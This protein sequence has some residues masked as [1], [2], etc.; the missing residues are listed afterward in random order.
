MRAFGVLMALIITTLA[1]PA[2]AIVITDGD[3][4]SWGL[5]STGTATTSREASGGNPGSRINITTVSGA[6][7]YGTAI[8]SD[9][10]MVSLLE[11][12]AFNFQIDV[13]SGPGARGQGQRLQ[14]LV[15]QNS[16][17]YAYNMGITGYP[18]NWD[19]FSYSGLITES[20]FTLWSG[21]GAATPDFSGGTD[22]FFGFAAGN[23]N[24][25]TLTQYYDNFYLKITPAVD[26][27][28]PGS[29][30]LLGLG[31]VGISLWSRKMI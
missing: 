25:G 10:S 7:V 4:N 28:E 31:L 24:S 8:K 26:V 14:L 20:A 27:P 11:G 3:F 30:A 9:F 1:S 15:E 17:I 13:L 19:T 29:L 18:L 16:S 2:H 12:S 6:T 21:S 22:T 23:S 5:G